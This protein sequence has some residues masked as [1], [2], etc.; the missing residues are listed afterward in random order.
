MVQRQLLHLGELN[1][2]QQDSW[3]WTIDIVHNDG[4]RRQLRLFTDLDGPVP[5]AGDVVQVKSFSMR[6]R[7]GSEWSAFSPARAMGLPP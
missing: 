3:Q 2:T 4:Q 6:S 7:D 5:K 1:T